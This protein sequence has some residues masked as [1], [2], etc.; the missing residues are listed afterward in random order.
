MLGSQDRG[1]FDFEDVESMSGPA[2]IPD[3]S[4]SAKAEASFGITQAAENKDA[5]PSRGQ[6]L[7]GKLAPEARQQMRNLQC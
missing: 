1:S 2:V 7:D 5:E 4:L 6:N 3:S